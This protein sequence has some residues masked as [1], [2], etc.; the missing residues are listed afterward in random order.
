VRRTLRAAAAALA[1]LL[2]LASTIL[3]AGVGGASWT[4]SRSTTTAQPSRFLVEGDAIDFRTDAVW[5]ESQVKG[6]EGYLASGLRYTHEVND[7]SGRLSATGY[8]ATNHPDPAYDRDD[9]D[10]DGRWEEAEIIAGRAAPDPGRVYTTIVQFS[11]W[12]GR[13]SGG[14]CEW[15]WDRRM[16][17]VEVLSQLSRDLLGEWQAERYTL[18]YETKPYPRVAPRPQLPEGVATARCRDQRPG[19]NQEG[20]VV[21]FSQPISWAALVDLITVGSG[22]WAA[23]EA[24]GSSEDDELL[25]TCGGPID[26]A[27][28]LSQCRAMGVRPDGITAAVGYFDTL[29]TAQLRDHPAV[30][31]VDPLRD[32]LTELLFDVGGF[33]VEAP[34]LTIND[35]YWELV[36]T[37]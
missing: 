29:A 26:D 27:V 23:F 7:R 1:A 6:L 10:G 9:D 12:H 34:G 16:G 3:A 13:R 2:L 31:A 36:L 4:P 20:M 14:S 5:D 21:T 28:R 33:G 30:I 17:G 25:W 24:I 37:A 11:R 19:V 8:W 15:R 18:T 22:K 35:R 32:S